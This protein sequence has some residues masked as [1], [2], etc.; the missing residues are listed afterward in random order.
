MENKNLARSEQDLDDCISSWLDHDADDLTHHKPAAEVLTGQALTT[1]NGLE[2]A[3]RL[4][5]AQQ[6]SLNNCVRE[7][8]MLPPFQSLSHVLDREIFTGNSQIRPQAVTEGTMRK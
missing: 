6:E 5:L 3:S 8:A 4:Q 1:S 7:S 2:P